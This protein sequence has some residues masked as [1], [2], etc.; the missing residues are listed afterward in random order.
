MDLYVAQLPGL[1]VATHLARERAKAD[2]DMP[3]NKSW[4]LGH[5]KQPKKPP[6]ALTPLKIDTEY[7]R[8]F[9]DLNDHHLP[10]SWRQQRQGSRPQTPVGAVS[11]TPLVDD[12]YDTRSDRSD[13]PAPRRDSKPRLAR[14]T[15][16]FANFKD[17]TKEPEFAFSAPWGEDAPQSL[18]PYID[19]LDVVQSVR[20]HMATTHRPIPMEHNSGLFRVF[21]DYRKVREQKESLS[22]MMEE[23]L[24]DWKKAEEHWNRSKDRYGAEIRRLEL[25]IARGTSGMAGLMQARQDSVLRRHRKTVSHDSIPPANNS[26]SHAQLDQEIKVRS[27]RA[28]LSR[29]L[30]PSEKMI[31]LS[32]QFTNDGTKLIV[33]TPPEVNHN[34]TLS[35]KVQSELNLTAI[36]KTKPSR[37]FTSS[38]TSGFSGGSGDPLPD[39]MAV[40]EHTGMEPATECE[41]L[42]AL[43]E[44]GTLVA[45]RRGL[46]VS[47]FNHS[48]MMLFSQTRPAERIAEGIEERDARPSRQGMGSNSGKPQYPDTSFAPRHNLR[49]FL[50]QPHL[51]TPQRHCRHFSFEPGA[52]QLEALAEDF[53]A[54]DGETNESG[55]DD[56][57]TPLL[58]RAERP[59]L[60]THSIR[61]TSSSQN[62]G[63]D[64]AKP[65]KI[66][67]PVQTM[68]RSRREDSASSL[69]SVYARRQDSRRESRSSVITVFREHPS[70]NGRPEPQSRH[71]SINDLRASDSSTG[72]R[73]QIGATRLR[74]S[75]IAVA[76]A[77]AASDAS[78]TSLSERSSPRSFLSRTNNAGGPVR[79]V[80]DDS[81]RTPSS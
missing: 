58:M 38:A 2:E 47:S 3:D 66:P 52:D 8:S 54:L 10:L 12:A 53:G 81:K 25:L 73:E 48:L 31:V 27:Q 59:A 19:P 33:G 50:S 13:T 35:R 23:T 28:L 51:S 76:A 70:G 44:L 42:V 41:A 36:H 75:N 57:D 32:T 1:S 18:Q 61:S 71:S 45:R 72:S 14:Y 16:L 46:E 60:D 34:L 24:S 55:S 78:Q 15:S 7:S 40:L 11:A 4:R 80:H 22:I 74:N 69:Q 9:D 56:S 63:A 30:S 49:K 6:K 64:L 29:P 39:E 77:R 79:P 20:S 43:R 67:S 21:E 5:S 62:L 65:S 26:L 37:S 17:T 68:G